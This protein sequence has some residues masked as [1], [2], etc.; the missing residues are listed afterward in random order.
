MF[1]HH[2]AKLT[3]TVEPADDF[4]R[5]PSPDQRTW[6]LFRAGEDLVH[7]LMHLDVL[8]A[9]LVAGSDRPEISGRW[10]NSDARYSAGELV[11]EGQQVMQDWEAP[12]MRAMAVHVATSGGDVLEV[13]FGMGISATY[14]QE[15]G[16]RSYTV[17][18]ANEDVTQRFKSWQKEFPDAKTSLI[19]GRWQETLPALGLYDGIFVDTYPADE[20]EY[21]D[22]VASDV[23]FAAHFFPHAAAHLRPVGCSAT[24]QTRSTR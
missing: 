13:G 7:D 16:V 10:Q 8:S 14:M 17:L 15:V 18:E 19:L 5:T 1:R 24:T 6:W 9:G 11:I 22:Y 4:I 23:T 2:S 3:V 21:M 20:G 12:L